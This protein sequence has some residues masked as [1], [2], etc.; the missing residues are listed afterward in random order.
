[1][2]YILYIYISN[3]FE[4]GSCYTGQAGLELSSPCL[5]PSS[6]GITGIS[7]LDVRLWQIWFAVHGALTRRVENFLLTAASGLRSLLLLGVH[8]EDATH[9][10]LPTPI[11]LS[12]ACC[13]YSAHG[14]TSLPQVL[15]TRGI[16]SSSLHL[17]A[18]E[19]ASFCHP[20]PAPL[21]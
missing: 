16:H 5:S 4:I 10:P 3:F 19:T 14:G 20:S 8:L 13:V 12:S 11:S 1:M 15:V 7:S 18:P 9:T 21:L 17:L 2:T 6:A